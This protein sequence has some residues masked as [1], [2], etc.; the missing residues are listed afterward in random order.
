M[1][2]SEKSFENKKNSLNTIGSHFHIMNL[3]SFLI[4][5][6]GSSSIDS[7]L[8]FLE[9]R[10][11]PNLSLSFRAVPRLK[12]PSNKRC[13]TFQKIIQ[14]RFVLVEF[15]GVRVLSRFCSSGFLFHFFGEPFRVASNIATMKTI[16]CIHH[17]SH[18]RES[19]RN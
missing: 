2:T 19:I 14:P 3:H 18:V 16:S 8:D 15:L 12:F 10:C 6:I 5:T 17:T 9:Y 13:L 11:F 4:E 1:S 7:S